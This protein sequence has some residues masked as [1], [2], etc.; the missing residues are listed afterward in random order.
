M[1]GYIEVE[2]SSDMDHNKSFTKLC[3]SLQDLC[4]NEVH[5]RPSMDWLKDCLKYH[6]KDNVGSGQDDVKTLFH[7]L[8]WKE[9][10][11]QDL[12]QIVEK[13]ERRT[14]SLINMDK[15]NAFVA[16]PIL[17]QIDSFISDKSK[18]HRDFLNQMNNPNTN[19]STGSNRICKFSVT[20]GENTYTGMEYQRME[21]VSRLLQMQHH[22]Y[23]E[24]L[25]QEMQNK[26]KERELRRK[27]LLRENQNFQRRRS[28][29]GED[30]PDYEPQLYFMDQPKG[31]FRE[32]E[33]NVCIGVK[34]LVKNITVN[35]GVLFMTPLNTKFLGGPKGKKHFTGGINMDEGSNSNVNENMNT[36]SN[37][38]NDFDDEDLLDILPYLD[39]TTNSQEENI[40]SHPD[41]PGNDIH[42][43]NTRRESFDSDVIILEDY[44]KPNITDK[45]RKS[46]QINDNDLEA[47]ELA[48]EDDIS[49]GE[50]S[51]SGKKLENQNMYTQDS[52]PYDAYLLAEEFNEDNKISSFIENKE[53]S[54]SSTFQKGQSKEIFQNA[55]ISLTST[56]ATTDSPRS[57]DDCEYTQVPLRDIWNYPGEFVMTQAVVKSFL[58]FQIN[59]NQ[60][61][62]TYK[63]KFRLQLSSYEPNAQENEITMRL[64]YKLLEEYMGMNAN[65]FVKEYHAKSDRHQEIIDSLE[66][67]V[68][69]MKGKFVVKVPQKDS[70]T[71]NI[72]V[73]TKYISIL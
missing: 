36:T 19:F 34:L 24:S 3:Q 71:E 59:H 52:F 6:K 37:N 12:R 70:T 18:S 13:K 42:G 33:I 66:D 56:S 21:D 31:T 68:S 5:F 14:L 2:E 29:D 38:Y 25:S 17:L 53:S 30:E 26:N 46:Y 22:Q 43:E 60:I 20:N 7:N 64:G 8:I 65:E 39:G 1:A 11:K 50:K 45:K 67:R 55:S 44:T 32:E 40:T 58:K 35:R 54:V 61:K 69:K 10:L 15:Q 28:L 48:F 57:L 49:T 16:G 23:Y 51:V 73:I 27:E 41:L 62:D 63:I 47:V 4:R 72:P 9:I